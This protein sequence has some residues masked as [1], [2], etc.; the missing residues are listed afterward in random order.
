MNTTDDFSIIL[1][2]QSGYTLLLTTQ[3]SSPIPP[4]V[5]PSPDKLK[6]ARDNYIIKNYSNITVIL[7]Q[8]G[9]GTFTSLS[10]LFYLTIHY[11][12]T[13]FST[14]YIL[15]NMDSYFSKCCVVFLT[16]TC[17][18]CPHAEKLHEES[19]ISVGQSGGDLP[20]TQSLLKFMKAKKIT[21]STENQ[22]A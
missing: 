19:T 1:T 4:R 9:E 7:Q 13:S 21:W 15:F 5:N 2:V 18:Q 11:F 20:T 6:N 10:D 22:K 3:Y 16:G 12:A 17:W 14:C 8:K